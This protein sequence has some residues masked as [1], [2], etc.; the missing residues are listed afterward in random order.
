MEEPKIVAQ[1]DVVVDSDLSAEK[2]AKLIALQR[3]EERLDYKRAYH[4]SG[5]KATKDKVELVRD[6][7]AMA[8]THG[9][10]IVLGVEETTGGD[11]KYE[12]VGINSDI[13]ADLDVD[14]LRA[15]IERY[16]AEPV[17]I[18]L[19]IHRL[20]EYENR[21]FACIYVPKSDRSPIIFEKPGTYEESPGQQRTVF[22]SGDIF[23]RRGAS[24]VKA[25]QNDMR[26]IISQI[27]RRE[28][29]RWT[30][31][32]LGVR[33][34]VRRL[35]LLIEILSG[36][37]IPASQARERVQYDEKNFYLAGPAFEEH[38]LE[39]LEKGQTFAIKRYLQSA[40]TV[41]FQHIESLD[42]PDAS[43]IQAVRDNNLLPVLDN[44]VVLGVVLIHYDERQLFGELEDAFYQM[45][46]QAHKVRFPRLKERSLHFSGSWV[47]R[48]VIIRIYTLGAVLVH[49]RKYEWVPTLI[50]QP[51]E[52]EGS[53]WRNRFWARYI[54]TM[55]AREGRLEEKSLCRLAVT[56]IESFDHLARL[57]WHDR[58][59][60][61]AAT[62]QFDFLQCIHTISETQKV[63]DGY[64]SFGIYNN[65]RTEPI[66]AELVT[67][68]PARAAI[69]D[70]SD[71]VLAD[72]IRGLDQFAGKEFFLYNGW[73]SNFWSD[74][75]IE[76][77]LAGQP[78]SGK[79]VLA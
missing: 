15:Q 50:R 9:G 19:Q 55:L 2:L 17:G 45:C 36:G 48:E 67:G 33:E 25:D 53:Y 30:E 47:W 23:V 77:F 3:E 60:I 21:A 37:E 75:S 24:S 70:M 65:Y 43:D 7:V 1:T 79:I 8:N 12:P 10:Y 13:V 16:L 54:L 28:K 35:D 52:W 57:F 38:I 62:C 72:I 58:D 61:I 73:D 71:D 68:G 32:I 56:Y 26:N 44:L 31:E 69:P 51:I 11:R 78:S 63:A 59:E 74:K 27:R 5:K 49:E 66:I 40:P 64:P 76:R 6:V 18:Q 20:P 14:R 4:L 39:L 34:L 29:E 41:F 46:K 22:H 42:E